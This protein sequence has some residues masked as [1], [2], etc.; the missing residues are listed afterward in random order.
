M[1]KWIKIIA[2]AVLIV[3]AGFVVTKTV[4]VGVECYRAKQEAEVRYQ[5]ELE[6]IRREFQ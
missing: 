1:Q 3:I 6:C 4:R 5:E 2:L